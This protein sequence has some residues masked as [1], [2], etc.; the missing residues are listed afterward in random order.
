MTKTSLGWI[1]LGV[2]GAAMATHLLEAGYPLTVFTRS[3]FKAEP[4]LKKGAKWAENPEEVARNA[5]IVFTMVGYPNDVEEVI[6]GEKGLLS[7]MKPGGIICDMTTSSPQLAQKIAEETTKARCSSLDAPVTGGDIGAKNA[8][9][10]IFIGGNKKDYE[11]IKPYLEIMGK[12]FLYC[13]GPGTGQMAKLANQVAVAGVMF[14]VCES[15]LFCKEAGIDEKAWLDL[16]VKGAAGSIAMNTLG[17][18]IIDSDFEPGFFIAHFVKDLGLC[19]AE[20]KKLGL[21]LP[22]LTLADELYRMMA[23]QGNAQDGTQ[24]LVDFIAKLSGKKW[25]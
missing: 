7:G 15:L 20:C 22:G 6:L 2:M 14:S 1:G 3:K 23:L 13:G 24:K 17:R 5:A 21:V 8:A 19:L 11:V 25:N 9:L 10:S 12:Q 4:L 18:R 16:V